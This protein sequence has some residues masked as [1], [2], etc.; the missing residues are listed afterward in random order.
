[1]SMTAKSSSESEVIPMVVEHMSR[2]AQ[3]NL[4]KDSMCCELSTAMNCVT[5]SGY[6][7]RQR[8]Q[9]KTLRCV[10][11]QETPQS[12]CSRIIGEQIANSR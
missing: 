6:L 5:K 11:N 7:G 8:Q 9:S 1:M 4:S 10:S 12:S 3:K 2:H